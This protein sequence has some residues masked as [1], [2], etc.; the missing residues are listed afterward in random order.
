MLYIRDFPHIIH[1]M[2][3]ILS[4]D[5]VDWYTAIRHAKFNRLKVAYPGASDEEVH[6]CCSTPLVMS[7]VKLIINEKPIV[8]LIWDYKG[9]WSGGGKYFHP[10]VLGR[11]LEGCAP[12]SSLCP[13]PP[14][15]KI[16]QI[17][18]IIMPISVLC[19]WYAYIMLISLF[20]FSPP[21]P[22]KSADFLS[23][24]FLL[25]GLFRLK[26]QVFICVRTP[27]FWL[28]SLKV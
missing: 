24:F 22:Q 1:F 17:M 14:Q 9:Y 12:K 28:V 18:L 7:V 4:Q 23:F 13:P 25:V 2:L 19:I 16:M 5:I 11:G 10:D 20:L 3:C 6:L 8:A 26:G 15:K 21:P 27:L